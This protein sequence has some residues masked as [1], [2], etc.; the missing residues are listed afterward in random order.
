MPRNRPRDHV[1]LSASI[2]RELYREWLDVMPVNGA[3]SWLI[4]NTIRN[5]IDFMRVNPGITDNLYLAVEKT[6]LDAIAQRKE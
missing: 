6:V 4:R 3:N 5:F 1:E 2:S